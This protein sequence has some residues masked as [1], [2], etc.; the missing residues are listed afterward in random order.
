MQRFLSLLLLLSFL[1]VQAQQAPDANKK[2]PKIG[3]VLSGG[4][5]KGLA[6]IGVLKVLEE[7]G[8]RPDYITGTSMGSI[9]GGLYASGYSASEL[10]SIVRKANWAVLLSD[11]IPLFDVVP[12]EKNDYNRFQL[13]FDI[14]KSGLS[15]PPGVVKGQRISE[16]LSELT[17]RVA[18]IKDFNELPIPFRCVA[19]DLITGERYVF[20]EGDLMTAMRASMA[21]P[22]VFTPV[23]LG[24]KYLVDGGVL[25]NFPVKECQKMGAD[26]IIGV[27]VGFKDFPTKKDMNSITKVLLTSASIGSHPELVEAIGLT[28]YLISPELAPYTTSSFFDGPKIIERGEAAAR[29]QFEL[30][31]SLADSLN[32]LAPPTP[33]RHITDPESIIVNDIQIKNREHI[34]K[35]FFISNLGFNEGDTVTVKQVNEGIR[36]LIGTRFYEKI[37]Y[38]LQPFDNGYSIVFNTLETKSAKAKFSIHYDTELK[39][40]IIANLTLR[41]LLTKNSRL[42]LTTDISES[43]RIYANLLTFLGEK[44]KT[45]FY[46][47]AYFEDTPLPIYREK[48]KKYGT[49]DYQQTHVGGGFNLSYGTSLQVTLG[50]R[51]KAIA[52]KQESGFNE[53]FEMGVDQ[54][55]NGFLH[56]ELNIESNTLNHRYFSTQGHHLKLSGI[57]NLNAYDIYQGKDTSKHLIKPYIGIVDKHYAFARGSY[58]KVLPINKSFQLLVKGEAGFFTKNS[59]FLNLIF[60]GG[61]NYNSAINDIP[62]VGLNYRE[63]LVENYML[64]QSVLNINLSKTIYAHAIIN[65][66]YS[67][68]FGSENYNPENNPFIM[69]QKEFILGYGIALSTN[70][71]IGPITIGLGT[72]QKDNRLRTYINIGF[73]FN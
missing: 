4:G 3:L 28:D 57:Y 35:S 68:P 23:E 37:T 45:G 33:V 15:L 20:K 60:L 46:L 22:S 25:D 13:E 61:T 43:P 21:I 39:A 11:Q 19:A 47:D 67:P 65:G 66:I 52:L 31:R 58:L 5:A 53:I 42:S 29:K 70:S 34:S 24:N 69:T 56:G 73:P 32:T 12:E 14:D 7:A 36:S 63:K 72:N 59:S 8:I 41:N 51:W 48:G 55:G 49:F 62:F 27:N 2:R 54:F 64:G 30:F 71:V 6:H 40:G 16:Y 18:N 9:I 26:I 1:S 38:E 50:L 17:W 44:Q 10:D